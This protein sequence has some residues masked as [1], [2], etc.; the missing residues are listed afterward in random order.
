MKTNLIIESARL[1]KLAGLRLTE[2][3]MQDK[4]DDLSAAFETASVETYVNLLKKYQSDKKVLAVLKAG[5]TDGKPTD[6][7]FNVAKASY[8]AKDLK[9]TQNE[10]GAEESLKNILTDQYGSLDGFLKGKASFPDPIITYNGRF[11]L[12]GH[13]RWS[14]LYA[15]NPNAKI[16]AINVVGKIDPKDILK[17]VHTAIAVDSGETKTISANLK[18]GNL[19][20]FTPE[21]VKSYVAEN[22]TDKARKVWAAHG[23][24][25]DEAIADKVA[26]N[27]ETMLTNSK[28]EKWAPSRD[29]MPQPGVSNSTEWGVDMKLGKVNLIAPKTSDTKKESVNRKLDSMLK[30]S[31]IKIK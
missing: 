28:P 30:E 14:Q 26:I 27:V 1:Q 3:E 2:D 24:E 10:I 11:V 21:K 22:L 4:L 29:S 17:A 18:A 31:F 20:A 12:D 5:L 25:S 13:H 7:K 19:L 9:P 8:S 16:Q 6:E 23:L 15:A